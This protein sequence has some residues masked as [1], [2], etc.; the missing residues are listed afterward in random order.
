MRR[1][2]AA[3]DLKVRI[4]LTKLTDDI[5]MRLRSMSA[6]PKA[7]NRNYSSVDNWLHHNG[8]LSHGDQEL[9]REDGDFAALVDPK[10]AVSLDGFVE[11]C[12]SMVPCKLT[13]VCP[14]AKSHCV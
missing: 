5:V 3:P 9:F 12:L 6:L 11:D 7:S 10:E 1:S 8:P 4:M 13:R 14:E 2:W